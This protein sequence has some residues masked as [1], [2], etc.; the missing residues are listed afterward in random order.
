[1]RTALTI[2]GSDSGGGAGIQADLKTFAAH[3]L[4]G[5]CAVT[6]VTAQNTLGVTAVES[7]TP[8]LVAAQIDAVLRDFDV[9]AI[10]TGMLATRD[11]VAVVCDRLE[12]HPGLPLVVDP[13]LVSTSGHALLDEEAVSLVRTRLLPRAAVVTPNRYEAEVLTGLS[14][15]TPQEA[16]AACARLREM[17]AAAVVLTGGD[18]DGLDAIDRLDNAGVLSELRGT[19]LQSRA[20]HGTGCTFSAAVAAQLARGARLDDAV[21]AAKRYVEEA[22]RHAFPLGQGPGPLNHF[23]RK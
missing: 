14:I 11:I 15:T 22:I 1:M 18:D 7:V 4:H 21:T 2:A 19:R 10:K 3:E 12:A 9:R 13:V 17:G 8:L 16:A 5:V 23:W 6:A 20:T